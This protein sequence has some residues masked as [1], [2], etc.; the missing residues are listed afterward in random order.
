MTKKA[1]DST[2]QKPTDIAPEK[3]VGEE[4]FAWVASD[5]TPLA[6]L[7][8]EAG[9][10]KIDDTAPSVA[11]ASPGLR[12]SSDAL[13]A[14]LGTGLSNSPDRS[15]ASGGSAMSA[16]QGNPGL[17]SLLSPQLQA[18]LAQVGASIGPR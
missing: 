1:K 17:S 10:G 18:S 2:P 4:I 16:L 12:I 11:P 8:E 5:D 15:G 14:L 7:P 13:G 3:L 9:H 6:G